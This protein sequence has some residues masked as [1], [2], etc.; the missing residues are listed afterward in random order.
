MGGCRLQAGSSR[1]ALPRGNRH[2]RYL[3][4]S[5]QIGFSVLHRCT[6]L[7]RG[8]IRARQRRQRMTSSRSALRSLLEISVRALRLGVIAASERRP[9]VGGRCIL[10]HGEG[11]DGSVPPGS[12]RSLNPGA[13]LL[14]PSTR[15]RGACLRPSLCAP[16]HHRRQLV[17]TGT[18]WAPSTNASPMVMHARSDR[19]VLQGCAHRAC[20][21]FCNLIAEALSGRLADS[22]AVRTACSDSCGRRNGRGVVPTKRRGCPVPRAILAGDET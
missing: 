12:E 16:A 1:A 22:S 21:S 15:G 6:A 4:K 8:A 17:G 14:G 18:R 7:H 9:P 10:P 20:K 5:L 11:V 13:F 3:A 19:Q 2:W